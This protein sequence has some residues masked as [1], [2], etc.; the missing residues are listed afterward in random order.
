MSE[1]IFNDRPNKNEK[2]DSIAY[3]KT[4]IEKARDE[5]REDDIPKLEKLIQML[6][7]KKYGLVWEEHAEKV[8][9]EMKTKIPIFV[10]DESK[11]INDNTDSEY[12]N[13]LLE[14]DNLHSLHILEKTHLGKID[15]IYIDPPYNTGAKNW[16]Y[17]NDFVDSKDEFKHSKWLSFMNSRL[18]IAKNLLNDTGIIV[19]TIDD[20]EIENITF[21]M[22]EIF[23]EKNRLG[24]VV[25]KN[26][27]QGRSSVTGFQISHEYA[28]FYGKANSK[29]GRLPRNENQVGR[30][31]NKDQFGLF[32][33]RNFR[34][35]YSSES[36]KMVYPIF[37]MKDG[38]DFRIPKMKW[39]EESTCWDLEEQPNEDELVSLPIDND[40][41]TRTWKWSID[42]VI[43]NKK[44]EMGVRLDRNKIPS[45]Y[46]KGRMKTEGM[47][48]YTYWD[49]PKYSASTFGANLL[50][51]LIGRGK[52][53]YPK[54]L[55]A[56][57]DCIRVASGDK[58][59]ILVLDFFAGSGTTGHAIAELNKE[60]GGNR[61]YILATN[62]ENNIAEEVTYERIKKVSL[63]TEKYEAHPMNLKYY[64]TDYVVKDEF[65]DVSLEYELL[66]Y[67]TPL[68]ELE[69]G[70]DITNPKVQI[71]LNE[72]QL[73]SLIDNKELISNSTIFMHPDVFR[74]DKQN[75][76]LQDLQIKIQEIPNY[77]FGSELWSK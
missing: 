37:V 55:Y 32:E 65:P 44:N 10:E 19:L 27:P 35:Q 6:N 77:F 52:F 40:G 26:N 43:K 46:Y 69:F 18:S 21:L 5:A 9:E 31:N 36:P 33:W 75:Q 22:N 14:G 49:D 45:V 62:N 70:I 20:Y 16:K 48:P 57:E 17:N 2:A 71:V 15:V 72:E 59:D 34:A 25:I 7:T 50:S 67:V 54:S 28:L 29:I 12:F 68:V 42:T 38:S 13:F 8:E 56:V 11:K 41:R 47:L 4:L 60:D 39:N 64:K 74:D 24:T 51:D 3:V 63:G 66:K 58:K 1:S 61:R 76:V 30:Y 23:G 53:N 73:E